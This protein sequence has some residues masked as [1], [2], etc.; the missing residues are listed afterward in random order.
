M[1]FTLK[2]MLKYA[3]CHVLLPFIY[4]SY[5]FRFKTII[6]LNQFMLF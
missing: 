5:L 3:S 1:S 2:D 6:N 4:F